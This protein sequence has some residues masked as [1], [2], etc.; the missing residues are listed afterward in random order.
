MKARSAVS[1]AFLSVIAV[2]FSAIGSQTVEFS[3][4]SEG[5]S[6][7]PFLVTIHFTIRVQKKNSVITIKKA[8]IY[9]ITS[10]QI[11]TSM[12]GETL[13]T[14]VLVNYPRAAWKQ[15]LLLNITSH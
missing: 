9:I 11:F 10:Q 1:V 8:Q 7:T 4:Y 5:I 12:D 2:F 3:H 6:Q 14:S 13:F 15:S